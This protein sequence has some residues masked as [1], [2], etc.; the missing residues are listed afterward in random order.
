[1]TPH[2]HPWR[3]FRRTAISAVL[4]GVAALNGAA[5]LAQDKPKTITIGST[6][7][8]HVKFI[9]GEEKKSFSDAF[10]ADGIKVELVTFDG[11]GSGAITALATGS[12]DIAYT[13]FAPALRAASTGADVRLI[14]LSTFVPYLDVAII[15]KKNSAITTIADLKGKKV[16]YLTGTVR[17]AALAKA[18]DL[19]KLNLKDIDGLNLNFDSSAPALIRG[20]VDAIVEST[21]TAQRLVETGKARVLIDGREHPEWSAPYAISVNGQFLRKYPDL[22]R[23]FLA[24]DLSLSRWADTHYDDTIRIYVR[25]TKASEAALRETYKQG[26]FYLDPAITPRAIKALRA[27]AALMK[28]MGLLKQ[29]IDFDKWID[30]SLVNEVLREHPEPQGDAQVR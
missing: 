28:T 12:L 15:V 17:Q 13:G 4:L 25:R 21:D 8:G 27:E 5:A 2:R 3:A 1:M 29:S 11:G 9:L 16:A 10:A 14:G 26:R 24:V 23:R 19:A 6:A 7:P 22:V 20:D 30:P 18:L